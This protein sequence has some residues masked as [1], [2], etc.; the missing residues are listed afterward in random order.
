VELIELAE[1]RRDALAAT[2]PPEPR[3]AAR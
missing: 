2:A 1:M 3:P